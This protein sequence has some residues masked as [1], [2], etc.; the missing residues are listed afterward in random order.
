MWRLIMPAIRDKPRLHEFITGR[1]FRCAKENK[2]RESYKQKRFVYN[3]IAVIM[4]PRISRCMRF[5]LKLRDFH[6]YRNII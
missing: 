2:Q 6:V 5:S 1:N 4:T 3:F